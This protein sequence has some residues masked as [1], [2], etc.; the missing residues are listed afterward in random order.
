M[1]LPK[2]LTVFFSL[3]IE[4]RGATMVYHYCNNIL[5]T[6]TTTNKKITDQTIFPTS[7]AIFQYVFCLIHLMKHVD[8]FHEKKKKHS[9]GTQK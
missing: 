7:K 8:N 6:T 1:V 3:K 4:T 9:L 5:S 2:N